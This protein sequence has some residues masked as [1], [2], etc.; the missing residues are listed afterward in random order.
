MHTVSAQEY[1]YDAYDRLAWVENERGERYTFERDPNGEVIAEC[2]FDGRE[3]RYGRDMDGTVLVTHLPDGTTIH[4]QHDLAGRLTYSR[5]PD[6]SWEAWEYDRA[7]RLCK[8]SNPH[9]ETV[10]ER[11]ALGRIVREIRNGHAIEHAYDSRSR[12]VR[13]LSDLG[14]DITH[15]YDD[16]GL[17]ESVK[18]IVQGMPHPWGGAHATRP[19][20]P[21][22]TAHD[23]GRRGLRHAVRRRGLAFTAK[24]DPP[25]ALLI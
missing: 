23:D 15:G 4:H 3:R 2:G 8:A 6:G 21:R 16:T 13:T 17:P 19:P 20:G 5:Y 11:D 7:G 10:F 22:E 1:G 18:A 12:L 25:R 14:A 24:R 9:G